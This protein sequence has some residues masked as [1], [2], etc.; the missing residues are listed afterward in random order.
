MLKN[1][2]I[3]SLCAI[4]LS[5]VAASGCSNS[6]SVPVVAPPKG[7]VVT[8]LVANN[9][10]YGAANTDANLQDAWGLAFSSFGTPWVANRASGTSTIYD[11]LGVPKST[12]YY[13][14]GPGSTKGNPTGIVQNTSI[15]SFPV[16]GIASSWIF[17]E[18]N[19]TI[20]ALSGGVTDST[21]IVADLS[22]S[23]SYTGL[24]L[25]TGSSGTMLYAPNIKNGS[26]DQF[27][28]NFGRNIQTPGKY[29]NLGYTPFNAVLIDTQLFVTH[30]K[31]SNGFVATGAGNGGY[32]DIFN[33]NGVFERNLISQD[34]LDEPWGVAIAPA[35]F[36]SFSG[37]L[38][39]GNFG[40][41]KI[42]VFD[43]S[44][45]ALLG[46]LN[47]ANGN[48]IVI[49][50]LWALVVQNGILYYTAGPNGGIDGVFGKITL[51]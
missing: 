8:P 29:F 15:S 33:T 3:I 26:L 44:S 13:I 49:P 39:V 30:A 38:L 17:S 10:T 11:T 51:P 32:V 5:L 19:G 48:G 47:D 50:G 36:E 6:S 1:L 22:S 42:N 34:S 24:A 18:F 40:D 46:R 4:L 27:N 43:P 16:N 20:A 14:N 35:S 12:Y 9:A 31:M 2:Q 45:G 21:T 25:V 7:F 41:G 37:K 28:S 23:S